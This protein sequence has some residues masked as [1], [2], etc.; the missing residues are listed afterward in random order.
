MLITEI[1]PDDYPGQLASKA[2]QLNDSFE[3]LSPPDL[4]VFQSQPSHYRMRAEFRVWHDDDIASYIM[5]APGSKH[6]FTRLE[7]FDPA[8]TRI[9]QLMPQLIDAVN[10]CELLR[11]RLFQ[12]EFLTTLSGEALITLVY[13]KPLD[14]E[15]EKRAAKLAKQLN[16]VLIGR[17]RKQ[18]IVLDRDYIN[19]ALL[20]NGITYRYQQ[21]EN[22]FTQPNA[23]V[24]QK[25]LRWA[26]ASCEQLGGD[27]LELYCG[28]GNFTIPL[29]GQFQR[30]LA[31]EISK[32]SVT[33]ARQNLLDNKVDNVSLVRMS[34]EEV[35]AA[36]EEVRPFRRLKDIDIKSYRFSTVFVDPP[37]AGLD[38]ATI[39]LI[40]GFDNILYISCNPETLKQN[41]ESLK[42]QYDI[43][44]FALFDQFPY[45]PHT[46]AGVL[47]QRKPHS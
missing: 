28:N 44:R 47:L 16:V 38:E 4:E 24:N 10:K 39:R 45:T 17:S 14:E 20:I 43:T 26:V 2:R 15:W 21:P 18:R 23:G 1:N 12:V 42:N 30:V 36:L 11:R 46:E 37:R 41:I 5:F 34:S 6:E 31:T 25:M 33:A 40:N 9:N 3:H 32:R 13:H 27:L 19:E 8:S 35:S 22:T 29:A 7:R